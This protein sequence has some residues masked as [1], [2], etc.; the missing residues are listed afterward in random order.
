M[1]LPLLL[2]AEW[3]VDSRLGVTVEQ[4]Y[5][6]GLIAEAD[7]PRFEQAISQATGLRNSLLAEVIMIALAYAFGYWVWPQR[8]AL[9]VSTWYGY[10]VDGRLHISLPGYW[11]GLVSLPI[12]RIILLR[13]YFRL[14]IWYRF[15]A[16]VSRIPL[17]LNALHPD[18]SGGLGF[19]SSSAYAFVPML[20]AQT[21]LMSAL[22]GN[23]IWH[24][25]ESLLQHKLEI[26]FVIA[27]L[28]VL[29]FLPQTFF[30]IQLNTARRRGSRDYGVMA[31]KYVNDFIA[32]W[33]G[34]G[35]GEDEK[36]VGSR[37]IQSLADLA[38]SFDVV[39]DMSLLPFRKRT[40]VRMG[41][42]IVLPLLPLLLTMVPLDQIIDRALKF[43]L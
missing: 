27:L 31:S 28:L 43:A 5:V 26:A 13:L 36:F 12:F 15:L 22:I 11:Y 25:G 40:V 33:T 34:P 24:A 2:F 35:A 30:V 9:H 7:R 42:V 32:K 39:N 16:K 21:F 8:V 41:L 23:H 17:Q 18:R 14:F 3:F 1:S 38:N 10:Y 20:L 6:R 29:V 19:L 37:D 4:F